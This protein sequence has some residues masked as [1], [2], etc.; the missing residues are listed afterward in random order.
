MILKTT[1]CDHVILPHGMPRFDYACD[2]RQV[3][4]LK[5]TLIFEQS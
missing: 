1:S 4:N 2:P 3:I 5:N